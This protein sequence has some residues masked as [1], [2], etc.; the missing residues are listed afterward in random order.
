MRALTAK[1]KVAPI[2]P[3]TIPR[4]ELSAAT[5]LVVRIREVLDLKRVQIK[6]E[7][8]REG[9]DKKKKERA[10]YRGSLAG[11]VGI[12]RFQNREAGFL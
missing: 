7:I 5:M 1:S 11:Q 9:A 12:D 4:L 8:K 2:K 10:S 6:E 3:V